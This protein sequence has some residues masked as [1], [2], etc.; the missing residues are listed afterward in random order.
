MYSKYEAD[1]L[2]INSKF[3]TRESNAYCLIKPY[4]GCYNNEN[5]HNYAN[6]TIL[7]LAAAVKGSIINEDV[8]DSL[9]YKIDALLY[10]AD[11]LSEKQVIE[12]MKNEILL[13]ILEIDY[14]YICVRCP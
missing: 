6:Y 1:L 12:K 5:M 14:D 4:V 11:M 10:S 9:Y 8:F 2:L 13:D 3:Y 7:S